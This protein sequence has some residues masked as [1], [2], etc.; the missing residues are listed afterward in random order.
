MKIPMLFL[1]DDDPDDRQWFEEA[2][3]GLSP[4]P[5][6]RSFPNGVE[7]MAALLEPFK[8]RPE[9][10]FLDLNMPMMTGEECLA[11]I[12]AEP[13]LSSVPVVVYSTHLDPAKVPCLIELGADRYFEKPLT[14]DGLG[15]E[16]RD[17]LRQFAVGGTAK[18]PLEREPVA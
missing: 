13:R 1:A 9:M 11:D 3:Q 10:I 15:N 18:G 7:L 14:M 5:V 8:P 6:V 16:L 2:L 4:V 12:R 17:C